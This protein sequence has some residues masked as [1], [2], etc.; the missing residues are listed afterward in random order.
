M[1]PKFLEGLT[2]DDVLLL[3]RESGIEPREAD[4]STTIVP[5]RH[6][7]GKG[8]YLTLPVLSAAMDRVTEEGMA[9]ALGKAGG[10][11]V[12]HR[13]CT[14]AEAVE[15]VRKAKTAG[16]LVAAACGPFDVERALALE[17]AGA[18]AVVIDCAHGHNTKVLESARKIKAK[19]RKN[20]ILQR[21]ANH[22]GTSEKSR[23]YQDYRSFVGRKPPA[24]PCPY[25]RLIA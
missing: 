16:V 18:D 24:F 13:N 15:M 9:I 5:A 14:I 17:A 6:P 1:E 20:A 23:I 21:S 3:P 19:L 10:L 11:G 25:R 12:L 7:G 4:L 8:I 22:Y 2:F